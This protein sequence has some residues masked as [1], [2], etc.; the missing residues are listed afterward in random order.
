M[1]P[2]FLHL[3]FIEYVPIASFHAA[4]YRAW[5]LTS[6]HLAL[7]PSN[8]FESPLSLG[9]LAVQSSGLSTARL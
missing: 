3:S 7:L 6:R 9:G 5:C 8:E 1:P 2:R 4:M